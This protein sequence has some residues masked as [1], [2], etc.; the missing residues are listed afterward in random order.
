[1]TEQNPPRG[2][3]GTDDTQRLPHDPPGGSHHRY[4]EQAGPTPDRPAQSPY[5]SPSENDTTR[6]GGF[7]FADHPEQDGRRAPGRP[8]RAVGSSP[9]SWWRRCS[10]AGSAAWL[11]PP[12][13]SR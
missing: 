2:N 13:S 5:S 3:D 8:A 1:M 6:F 12:G 9:A 4:G 11:A 10:S 7:G